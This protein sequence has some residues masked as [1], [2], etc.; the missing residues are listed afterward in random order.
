M[1]LEPAPTHPDPEVARHGSLDAYRLAQAE[2]RARRISLAHSKLL[3]ACLSGVTAEAATLLDAATD[4][5]DSPSRV[6]VWQAL[7]GAAN[8]GSAACRAVL[9][10]A[11]RL[12]A[13]DIVDRSPD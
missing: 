6:D 10:H 2:D 11:T 7:I 13:E 4:R 5:D 9:L 3:S 8:T 1:T 12:A